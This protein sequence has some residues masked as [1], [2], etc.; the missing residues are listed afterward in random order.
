MKSVLI[1]GCSDGGTGSALAV[2]FQKRGLHVF[3]TTREVSKMSSLKDLPNV[4]LLRLDVT[5]SSSIS[6]AVAAVSAQ[7]KGTLDYLVNNAAQHYLMPTLDVNVDKAK[8]MFDVNFWG[9]LACIQ[10]FA[11]LVIAAQGTIVNTGSIVSILNVPYNSIYCASKAAITI[12]DEVLRV[13]MAPLKVKVLTTI[14]GSIAT[15]LHAT[16]AGWEPQPN[17]KYAEIE[18]M[19]KDRAYNTKISGQTKSQDYA[20]KVV[21]DILGG[22]TGKI[23]RGNGAAMTR[24]LSPVLPQSVVVCWHCTLYCDT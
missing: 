12:F 5:D 18:E 24:Y 7:T 3:A 11:P 15:N 14:P 9:K 4:T 8:A 16:G 20:E 21:G 22:A 1:T 2:S 23:W 6:S 10:A 17:S 13:E 19:I